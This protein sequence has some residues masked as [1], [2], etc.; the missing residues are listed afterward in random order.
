MIRMI[1]EIGFRRL[2]GMFFKRYRPKEETDR[3]IVI[4]ICDTTE[5]REDRGRFPVC[6]LWHVERHKHL[7]KQIQKYGLENI[8]Q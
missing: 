7:K 2:N 5:E 8:S 1:E 3:T 4:L 6:R